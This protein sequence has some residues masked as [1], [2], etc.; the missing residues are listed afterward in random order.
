MELRSIDE[1]GGLAGMAALT[2]GLGQEN[3]RKNEE[4]DLVW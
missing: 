2:T 3:T 4:A 1:L